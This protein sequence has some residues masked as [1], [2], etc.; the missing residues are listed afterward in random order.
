L[1][2]AGNYGI[3][4]QDAP[5]VSEEAVIYS[6]QTGLKGHYL[7]AGGGVEGDGDMKTIISAIALA[8]LVLGTAQIAIAEI[9][10]N[11]IINN[12]V[13]YYIQTDKS[14]YELGENVNILYRVS[15]L[16][17]GSVTLGRVTDDPP[18]YYAF[19][20]TQGNNQIW[21]YFYMTVVFETIPFTLEPL[22][23]K[24][25]QTPWNM[26]ND[27][28]TRWPKTDDFLINPGVYNIIGELDLVPGE[29]VP[30]SVSINVI[31]EPSSLLLVGTG[32]LGILTRNRTSRKK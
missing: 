11:S 4:K 30:V 15:N 6:E 20:V 23:T 5:A 24:E 1:N 10:S 12:G 31:P 32:L 2:K 19:R 28:G 14:I 18:A 8:V 21:S 17:D 3:I 7:S 13:Q 29:R 27:N 22:Q 16:T 26:M 9:D 25:F